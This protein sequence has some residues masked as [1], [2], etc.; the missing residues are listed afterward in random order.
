MDGISTTSTLY[1]ITYIYNLYFIVKTDKT[2]EK[3]GLLLMI[4]RLQGYNF[5][6]I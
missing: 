2:E 6:N 5:F 3:K 4:P 1:L